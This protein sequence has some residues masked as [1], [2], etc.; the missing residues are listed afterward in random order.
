[1]QIRAKFTL[2]QHR[3]TTR[4][5]GGDS[6]HEFTFQPQYDETLPEDRRFAKATPAGEFRMMVDNPPVIAFLSANPGRQFYFD[7]TLAEKT[8]E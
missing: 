6:Y 3:T 4:Y 7:M 8:S 2:T 5:A 1:M